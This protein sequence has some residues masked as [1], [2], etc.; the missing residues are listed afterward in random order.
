[1]APTFFIGGIYMHDYDLSP[2]RS[3]PLFEIYYSKLPEEFARTKLE[4]FLPEVISPRTLANRAVKRNRALRDG[5]LDDAERSAPPTIRV[6]REEHFERDS[7]I[8]WLFSYYVKTP[9]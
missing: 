1:M 8:W 4:E 9:V 2:F 3:H 5:R 6:G 7:F